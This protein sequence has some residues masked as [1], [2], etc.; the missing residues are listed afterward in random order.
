MG[1]E[2]AVEAKAETQQG[3]GVPEEAG[4]GTGVHADPLC[5]LAP[6]QG[7]LHAP[8]EVNADQLKEQVQQESQGEEERWGQQVRVQVGCVDLLGPA[9][10]FSH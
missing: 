4:Q 3:P 2:G 7:F 5:P 10:R 1:V 9:Q 6:A 8:E